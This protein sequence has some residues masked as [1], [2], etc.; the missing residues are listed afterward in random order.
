VLDVDHL[1][2]FNDTYGHAA[3]DLVLIAVA[4][5]MR[6]RLRISDFA[7]RTGGDEFVVIMPETKLEQARWA[8]ERI[9]AGLYEH[10]FQLS[11]GPVVRATLSVGAAQHQ[12]EESPARLLER[13]D[14]AMYQAKQEG[15]NRVREATTA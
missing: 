7:T 6:Q 11:Q 13:A 1:K 4:Q 14:Q 8:A 15:K 5:V 2:E 9:R 3:G 12:G 10:N